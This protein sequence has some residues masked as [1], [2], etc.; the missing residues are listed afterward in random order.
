MLLLHRAVGWTRSPWS[1][2]NARRSPDNLDASFTPRNL[3]SNWETKISGGSS[4]QLYPSVQS[5]WWN[6]DIVC[7]R[8][9]SS[10]QDLPFY[11]I[12]LGVHVTSSSLSSSLFSELKSYPSMFYQICVI[13]ITFSSLPHDTSCLCILMEMFHSFWSVVFQTENHLQ[14]RHSVL[15]NRSQHRFLP[16]IP[17]LNNNM[18]WKAAS[19]CSASA[20]TVVSCMVL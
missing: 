15:T 13:Y 17:Y 11:G 8:R 16:S 12:F 10:T 7:I 9:L 6:V 3:C 18:P 1:Y 14:G 5:V 2:N 4:L 20:T 19:A